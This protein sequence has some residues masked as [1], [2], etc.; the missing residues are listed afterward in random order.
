MSVCV[1]ACVSVCMCVCMK[2][3]DSPT[4]QKVEEVFDISSHW[5]Q[6]PLHVRVRVFVP[7]PQLLSQSLQ[8]PQLFQWPLHVTS[9][10]EI[11]K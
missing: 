6:S 5:L 2:Y 7:L 10:Y 4:R 9:K 3:N 1:C 11:G 8:A